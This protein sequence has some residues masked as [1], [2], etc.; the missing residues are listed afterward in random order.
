MVQ[1]I[2]YS[3]DLQP[4]FE[5]INKEW[6]EK[7]FTMEPF[8]FEQLSNPQEIILNKGGAILFAKE[9]EEIIGTVGLTKSADGTFEMV[10]MAVIPQAQGKKVGQL[11]AASILE[12]AKTMGAKKV[13]LY[14]NTKLEAA[15]SL[16]RKFGFKETPPE[17]G[18]YGRC[19]I[20]MEIDL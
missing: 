1:I 20:K 10:K 15:L 18:K 14:S 19:D 8:D 4:H 2:D 7:Y 17:C 12:K 11:L 13:V 9:G 16:Y 6:V 5:K 3:P